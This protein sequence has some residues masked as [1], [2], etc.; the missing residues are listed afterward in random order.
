[1][2]I[3]LPA[4]RMQL[5]WE[6]SALPGNPWRCHYELVI[7]LN[8]FDIRRDVYKGTNLLKRKLPREMAIPMKPPSLRTTSNP[9]PPCTA[10][11]GKTRFADEPFRDGAHALWDAEQLGKLPVFVIAPDG[12]AFPLE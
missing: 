11:D 3:K 7:L 1:M 2:A 12:A 5:R 4:P 10:N 6:A 9:Y 8:K